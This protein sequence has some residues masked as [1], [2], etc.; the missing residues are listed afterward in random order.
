VGVIGMDKTKSDAS[1]SKPKGKW[2]WTWT[3]FILVVIGL[4][5][6]IG[7]GAWSVDS[8]SRA[9]PAFCTSCHL[10][11]SHVDSYLHGTS[12]DNVHQRA[13][14][15]CKDC[16]SD[17]SYWDEARSV[18]KYITDDYERVLSR[19]KVEDPMCLKCHISM[20]YVAV[21]TD[22]LTRNPHLSHWPELRCTT[23]HLSH[24]KQVDYCSRCHENG[25]QRMTGGAIVPR[26]HNP[27]ADP[28]AKRPDVH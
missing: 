11:Q 19:R 25:G 13:G 14:V 26:A 6:V 20:A 27:W 28:N 4:V 21:Q 1:T 7:V 22:H 17:Y 5:N 8:Y 12:M 9:N 3:G 23:C 16:H 15:G 18:I 2:N 10:M 24:D